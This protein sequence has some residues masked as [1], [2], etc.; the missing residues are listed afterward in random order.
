MIDH[1]DLHLTT[2]RTGPLDLVEQMILNH[3]AQIE[4][5]FRAQW[6][7]T[8]PL[9]TSS[10]D[11]RHAGFKLAPVD[12][13]LF[14]AGFN[15]L[16][17]AFIPLCVQACREFLSDKIK[18]ILLIPEEHTRNKFYLQSLVIL[19]KILQNSG[20]EVRIGHM[21]S[22]KPA[23][24]VVL[25]NNEKV[26]FEPITRIN[27]KLY[28]PDFEPCLIML[29]NDL[30]SG[31]PDLLK[32]LQQPMQP[33]WKLGWD[34]RLKSTHFNFFDEVTKEFVLEFSDPSSASLDSWLLNPLSSSMQGIDFME[35]TGIEALAVAVNK[36]IEKIQI[37]YNKYNVTEKPF[38]VIKADNGT[39]GMGVMMVNDGDELLHLNR[40]Q[41]KQM[42]AT[43]GSRRLS[44]VLIQEGIYSADVMSNNAVAEPVIYMI[45]PFVV[46]G[47]YR[48]HAQRGQ[49]ENLNAPGMHFEPLAFTKSPENLP[50]RFYV[51]GVIA[52]L[53]ALAAAREAQN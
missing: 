32:N 52:R 45:G 26:V 50:N 20:Y 11:L 25:E 17:P 16:N 21:D 8:P 51:Y 53:A 14:P 35:K 31:V 37:Q 36:L 47:F 30:S 34:S 4:D 6:L 18:R 10:V 24:E 22:S 12:T 42:S 19:R 44:R 43:K 28:L 29:N 3:M 49:N 23:F 46:G 2:I 38:V 40:R 1:N 33:P 27:N 5:W 9:I 41:R 7:K 39:Y 15:N 13:N 48:V